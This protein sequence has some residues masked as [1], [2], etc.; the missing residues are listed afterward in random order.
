MPLPGGIL[1]NTE[2]IYDAVGGRA[3][4]PIEDIGELWK[5]KSAL[6]ASRSA[7][8]DQVGSIYENGQKG[9]G[10]HLQAAGSLLVACLGERPPVSERSDA[11]QDIRGHLDRTDLRA[12][13]G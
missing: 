7:S 1:R 4:V 13:E 11:R 8:A 10:S 12:V 3:A 6:P 9:Q 2:G 5:G